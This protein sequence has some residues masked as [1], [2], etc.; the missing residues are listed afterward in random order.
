VEYRREEEVKRAIVVALASVALV[1]GAKNAQSCNGTHIATVGTGNSDM[2]CV[3]NVDIHADADFRDAFE[4]E[5]YGNE[6]GLVN[7]I[8]SAINGVGANGGSVDFQTVDGGVSFDVPAGVHEVTI[9]LTN[10]G[11][12]NGQHGIDPNS[13][14]TSGAQ[15]TANEVLV[16]S[17]FTSQDTAPANMQNP[18][19]A[20]G[21]QPPLN[22]A[23]PGPGLDPNDNESAMNDI[24]KGDVPLAD[25]KGQNQAG[26]KGVIK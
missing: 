12:M 18:C 13:G 16:N 9:T 7:D 24:Q 15:V 6:Q 23:V 1:L 8:A 10:D 14:W 17:T 19:G 3:F 5:Y 21:Y 22:M 2:G 26:L 25:E 20:N 11:N 4:S